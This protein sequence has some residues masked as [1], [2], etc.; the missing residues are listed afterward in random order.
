MDSQRV[1]IFIDGRNLFYS[2]RD[3]GD[4]G[5]EIDMLELKEQLSDEQELIRA[6]WYDSVKPDSSDARHRFLDFLRTNGFRVVTSESKGSEGDYEE[7]GSDIKLA[8]E[9]L[10]LAHLDAYDIAILV[11]GDGD[12]SGAVQKTQDVGKVVNVASFDD[13]LSSDLNK[14][15]DTT[16]ELDEL[17]SQIRMDD[18]DEEA[19]DKI[20][21]DFFLEVEDQ[22]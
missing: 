6:Y 3:H 14:S 20:E 4:E 11:S 5:V 1:M 2:A 18:T 15:S 21:Q 8:C 13:H 16:I 17:V 7:K 9:M 22:E 10:H 19:R 12:F